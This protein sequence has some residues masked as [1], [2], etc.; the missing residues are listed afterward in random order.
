MNGFPGGEKAIHET[1]EDGNLQ[2]VVASLL[3][4][5]QGEEE[6]PGLGTCRALAGVGPFCCDSPRGKGLPTQR[7]SPPSGL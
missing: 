1:I 4:M 7:D 3:L 2:V 5:T 6:L